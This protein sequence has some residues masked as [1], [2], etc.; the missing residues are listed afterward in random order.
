M[1]APILLVLVL[2]L[3]PTQPTTAHDGA[4]LTE[5]PDVRQPE[6]HRI[7]SGALDA[8]DV[9]RIRAAGVKHLINLR[10]PEESVGF[11]E[12]RIATGLGLD[13][14]AIPIAGAQS[15]TKDNARRLDEL[16]EQAGDD[17]TLIHC[18]SGN[19]VGALIALR[20]AW[21]KGQPTDAAIAEGR[22]WGLTSLEG[23]VR[24]ALQDTSK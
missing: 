10:T 23:A 22:R 24:T 7:V 17:L 2:C 19:R 9:G 18:A 21:I 8:A 3:G 16:L 15:L 4:L 12:A 6:D 5:V 14:H 13:Y 11:D 20:E 1:K